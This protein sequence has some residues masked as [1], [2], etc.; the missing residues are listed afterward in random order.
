VP[1]YRAILI[2]P[3]K[4]NFTEI[5]IGKG[6]KDIYKA[7]GC[8]CFTTGAFLTGSIEEGFDSVMVSDDDLEDRDDPRFWFQVDADRN[9]SFP[10]AGRGLV[11]G[12]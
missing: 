9:P 10:I 1:K 6:I 8:R 12:R 4:R 2:D 3:E 11:T 5:Q 7:I